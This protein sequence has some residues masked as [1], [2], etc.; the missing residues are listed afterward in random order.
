MFEWSRAASALT[1]TVNVDNCLRDIE[2][3]GESKSV[4]SPVCE[5]RDTAHA[6]SSSGPA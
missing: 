3:R 2:R 5:L 6:V 1:R 4:A